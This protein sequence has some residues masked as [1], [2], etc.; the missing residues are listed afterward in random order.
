MTYLIR[1]L[2]GF[3]MC[4]GNI[5]IL[6]NAIVVNAKSTQSLAIA[7]RI[8]RAGSDQKLQQEQKVR[9]K[10]QRRR[11][12]RSFIPPRYLTQR[13]ANEFRIAVEMDYWLEES[14]QN[15]LPLPR[16]SVPRSFRGHSRM[17]EFHIRA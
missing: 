8:M 2:H 9:A 7:G 1:S 12:E 3:L 10:R 6:K 15:A 11:L 5:L 13:P 14:Y 4:E 17:S 16:T